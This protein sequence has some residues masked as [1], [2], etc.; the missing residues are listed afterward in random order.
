MGN[1]QKVAVIGV[2]SSAG[3]RNQGQERGPEAL[4][5]TGLLERLAGRGIDCIDFG[6]LP[7]VRY[8]RDQDHPK[9]QNLALVSATARQ[10]ADRVER[11]TQR[12]HKLLVI[13][14]DCT[15]TLGVLAGLSRKIPNLG[16]IYFDGDIDMN[17]SEDTPSGIL[18]GMGLAHLTGHVKNELSGIGLSQ[19]L[20]PEDRI[21]VFG[22]NVDS[23][24]IDPAE[25]LRFDE[26]AIVKFSANQIR[27]SIREQ[28]T[29]A[30][31]LLGQKVT[32]YLVHFDVDVVDESDFPAA[33][34]PHKQ[35]IPLKTATA[36]LQTF[37]STPECAGLVVTEYNPNR[38]PEGVCANRLGDAILES[39]ASH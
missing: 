37:W 39:I 15:L 33:D 35:G 27:N 24:F 36:A 5:K 18:D 14:G 21:V 10:V 16:L 29:S 8:Q 38:D 22:Y 32:S 17:T 30:R 4:R 25:K 13:G 23:G 31:D 26:S 1:R 19:P 28:A 20:M 2:P 9:C 7:M 6:D 3:A 12:G 11:A 34:V